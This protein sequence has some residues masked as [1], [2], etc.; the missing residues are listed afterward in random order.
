MS[1]LNEDVFLHLNPELHLHAPTGHL[2]L[3]AKKQLILSK[4]QAIS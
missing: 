3:P 1:M 4:R 2:Q